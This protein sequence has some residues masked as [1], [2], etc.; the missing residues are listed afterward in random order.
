[1]HLNYS[2]ASWRAS[3]K[4]CLGVNEKHQRGR[5]R[6]LRTNLGLREST[7]GRKEA[8]TS[9]GQKPVPA[10][11]RGSTSTGQRLH[12]HR[13]EA[14]TR[15]GQR[16]A[17]TQDRGSTRTGQRQHQNRAEAST[18]TGQRPAENTSCLGIASPV[19]SGSVL[20]QEISGGKASLFGFS[21]AKALRG[22]TDELKQSRHKELNVGYGERNRCMKEGSPRRRKHPRG[23]TAGPGGCTFTSSVALHVQQR[24]SPCLFLFH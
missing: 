24:P 16:P 9:T 12:Q 20:L 6:F 11:G 22:C 3:T 15:S 8:S 4:C 23:T 1:M 7:C 10:Q 19:S 5:S 18:S 2:R 13:A 14:S 17:P 21:S